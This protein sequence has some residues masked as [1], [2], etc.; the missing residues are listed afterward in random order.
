MNRSEL[1]KENA[2]LQKRLGEE[3]MN[4][5]QAAKAAAKRI[6][7]NEYV[8]RMQ[9]NDIKD[10]NSCILDMIAGKSPCW[11]CEENRLAECEHKDSWM[12][13][14]CHE[15]WLRM[16]SPEGGEADAEGKEAG[17]PILGLEEQ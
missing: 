14:G 13:A 2:K 8:I 17:N 5:R 1:K 16:K 6:E 12:N 4:G 11:W 3:I 7:E 9:A 10:Y 15:W